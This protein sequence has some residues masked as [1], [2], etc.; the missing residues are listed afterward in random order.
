[1]IF[2]YVIG[3]ALL[4][5]LDGGFLSNRARDENERR[6]R[7]L[8]LRQLQREQAVE[9]RQREVRNDQIGPE[10]LQSEDERLLGLDAL[11]QRFDASPDQM[12]HGELRVELGV[13]HKKYTKWHH[14]TYG[15]GDGNLRP[16]L[17]ER[18]FMP[19]KL[20]CAIQRARFGVEWSS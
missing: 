1:I 5:R 2:Q 11:D 3:R 9:A 19:R 15:R 4:E 8:L 6:G 14:R 20:L 17:A 13:F 18:R 7:T 10:A 16:A 12:V